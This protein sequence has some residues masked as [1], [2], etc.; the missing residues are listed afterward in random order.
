M[1]SYRS[2]ISLLNAIK[3]GEYVPPKTG[4]NDSHWRKR[5][6][7]SGSP[8]YVVW[9]GIMIRYRNAKEGDALLDTDPRWK[10]FSN[11][12][13]DMGERPSGSHQLR[14]LDRTKGFSKD[15]CQWFLTSAKPATR[16]KTKKKQRNQTT[17]KIVTYYGVTLTIKEWAELFGL[18]PLTL[19]QRFFLRKWPFEEALCNPVQSK[20]ARRKRYANSNNT[21]KRSGSIE[22]APTDPTK[23][24]AEQNRR[25]ALQKRLLES[26]DP[27]LVAAAKRMNYHKD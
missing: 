15:N 21:K 22:Y 23:L 19:Y 20:N 1:D 5:H 6:G 13:E 10:D 8:T 11:F 4:A 25:R 24:T 14:R 17:A 3:T 27:N 7:H 16:K 12:L 9:N 18:P 2:K 26:N